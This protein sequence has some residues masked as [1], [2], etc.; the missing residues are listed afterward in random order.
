MK[1]L[2]P[3]VLALI[4]L[5]FISGCVNSDIENS[6]SQYSGSEREECIEYLSVY[7][8]DPYGCYALPD[9]TMV[10]GC[11]ERAVNPVESKKL[12]SRRRTSDRKDEPIQRSSRTSTREDT[13]KEEEKVEEKIDEDEGFTEFDLCVRDSGLGKNGCIRK[14]AIDS[15]D[16][17]KCTEIDEKD[18]R[19]SCITKIAMRVKDI[20]ICDELENAADKQ[21]CVYF[22][23]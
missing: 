9:Q 19:I 20:G 15:G 22:S 7:E 13:E 21:N 10:E 16:I 4:S 2:V 18:V 12:K 5:V 23:S 8:Q 14:F 1:H 6:C 11:L 3:V 17:K